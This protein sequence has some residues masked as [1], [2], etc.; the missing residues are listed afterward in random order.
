MRRF[1]LIML[2]VAAFAGAAVT[3][4]N[5]AQGALNAPVA[6]DCRILA[7][8]SGLPGGIPAL[9]A[10]TGGAHQLFTPRPLNVH[11]TPNFSAPVYKAG[12]GK[13]AKAWSKNR[14]ESLYRC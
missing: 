1:A 8:M 7:G 14:C 2:A 6:T 11:P 10:G 13:H 9:H 12:P 4:S 5:A 3:A